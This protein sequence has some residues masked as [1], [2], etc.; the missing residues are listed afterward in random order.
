MN[1]DERFM[2]AFEGFKSAHG[3]TIISEERRAGKQKAQSRTVRTPITLELIRSHLNGVKGVGSIPI[4]E[5]N[6]CKFG[7]LDI[8]EYPLDL[9]AI[10]RRLRDLEVPAVVCRSKS[11][12]AHIYF[13]FTEFMSAGEFRD[14]ASE[15]AAYVGYGRCEIFPK[16]EQVLHERGDVGNFINLPYFDAEQTLRHAILED[17]SAASL[18]EFLDLADSRAITP[19]AFVRLPSGL[20]KTSSRNGRPA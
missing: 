16:Q 2:A 12:G 1:L 15:I 20:S 14:K 11:G 18:E 3:Q 10:D 5:D 7:V 8:D 9:A 6:K 17:G 19:E 13:F 4:N